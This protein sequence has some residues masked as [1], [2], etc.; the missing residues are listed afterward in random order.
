M[1]RALT[2]SASASGRLAA[3]PLFSRLLLIAA[4]L[5]GLTLSAPAYAQRSV[6]SL[7]P[8]QPPE[9]VIDSVAGPAAAPVLRELVPQS[10]TVLPVAG[11]LAADGLG[12]LLMLAP[13]GDGYAVL[14]YLPDE[15]DFETVYRRRGAVGRALAVGSDGSFCIGTLTGIDCIDG[16]GRATAFQ[17][18]LLN[19][20]LAVTFAADGAVWALRSTTGG[21]DHLQLVRLQRHAGPDAAHVEPVLT[22][23][24]SLQGFAGNSL[25]PADDGGVYVAVVENDVYRVLHVDTAGS[26]SR[27]GDLWRPGGALTAAA[28]GIVLASGVKR[29]QSL[30]EQ[31]QPLDV[32]SLVAGES[33]AVAASFPAVPA[34]FATWMTPYAALGGDGSLH[35]IRREPV[36]GPEGPVEQA[37]LWRAATTLSSPLGAGA[38]VID[39]R[40]PFVDAVYNPR[41]DDPDYSGPVLVGRGQPL[42]IVG[43]NFEGK[44]GVRSV[45]V[46]GVPAR[47][48]FWSDQVVIVSVP[49]F[50]PA[51]PA[52]IVVGIDD[53]RSNV[54]GIEVKTPATPGVLQVGTPSMAAVLSGNAGISGYYGVVAVQGLTEAGTTVAHEE[55]MATPGFLQL[56]LPNGSYTATFHAAYL[57]STVLFGTGF[58]YMASTFRAAQ[59]PTQTLEFHITDADPVVVWK[60]QM[61]AAPDG[62]AAESADRDAGTGR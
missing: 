43:E 59:V 10:V 58:T 31:R 49:V 30:Q 3:A 36:P 47:A 18:P 12:M 61:L 52:E 33:V 44:S 19:D 17:H 4:L 38:A 34:G 26:V 62:E 37:V 1:A 29:P 56:R 21:S 11:P 13:A 39:F 45:R 22:L 55:V 8:L 42:I 16:R 20:I 25:A 40:I 35:L 41:F 57:E 48:E 60:P 54:E 5:T 15:N 50:A 6:R 14:R 46:G 28:G 51:G 7:A 32:L 23:R 53:V 2:L 24:Q 27:R 9:A